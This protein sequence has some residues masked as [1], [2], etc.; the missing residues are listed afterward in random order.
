MG[1]QWVGVYIHRDNDP[2]ELVCWC[3]QVDHFWGLEL[4]VT[5]LDMLCKLLVICGWLAKRG[6]VQQ[7]TVYLTLLPVEITCYCACAVV[8]QRTPMVWIPTPTP[9]P[10]KHGA[11]PEYLHPLLDLSTLKIHLLHLPRLRT[12]KH[13]TNPH[14]T[15]PACKHKS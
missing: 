13:V 12:N 14:H 6:A 4:F 8:K 2:P 9:G 3:V 1:R 15:T 7:T 10:G 11:L 5:P